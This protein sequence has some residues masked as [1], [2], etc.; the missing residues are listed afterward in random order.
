MCNEV[1]R[2]VHPVSLRVSRTLLTAE[3]RKSLRFHN[4]GSVIISS[5]ALSWL[6]EIIILKDVVISAFTLRVELNS[7]TISWAA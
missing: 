4:F 2:T 3:V 5:S 1:R 6:I 7:K